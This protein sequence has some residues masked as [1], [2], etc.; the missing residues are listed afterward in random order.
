MISTDL[1]YSLKLSKHDCSATWL[2]NYITPEQQTDLLQ[3]IKNYSG[4]FLL[5]VKPAGGRTTFKLFTS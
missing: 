2:L 1:G 4:S 5:D 3:S